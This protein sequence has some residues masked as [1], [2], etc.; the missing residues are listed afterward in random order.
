ML[1]GIANPLPLRVAKP[2]FQVNCKAIN[3]DGIP[4]Q[5]ALTQHQLDAMKMYW[6]TKENAVDVDLS[7]DVFAYERVCKV[8]CAA[9][10]RNRFE[11]K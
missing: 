10:Y 4:N 7:E 1:N 5:E 2:N 11:T 6:T 8:E 9:G 3:T